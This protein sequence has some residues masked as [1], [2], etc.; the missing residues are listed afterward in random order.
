M[1]SI[2]I[3]LSICCSYMTHRSDLMTNCK[4]LRAYQVGE[5]ETPP[6]GCKRLRKYY[7]SFKC[8]HHF[9]VIFQQIL[10]DQDV[11]LPN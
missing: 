9:Y 10:P 2:I 11:P 3:N 8:G 6:Q 4:D 1:S 5:S 7:W